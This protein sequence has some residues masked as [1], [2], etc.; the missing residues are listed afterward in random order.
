M[1]D[2]D[3]VLAGIVTQLGSITSLANRASAYGK[4]FTDPP[5]AIV[6]P[7]PGQFIS[8]DSTMGRGSDDLFIVIKLIVGAADDRASQKALNAYL[9]TSGSGS[10]KAAVDG[11]LGG[12][13]SFATVRSARNYG[14]VE[15]AGMMFNGCEFAVEVT[16]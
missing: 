14:D 6:V 2:I 12:A 16:T 3:T 13:V 1:T 9:A 10:V 11:N 8:F 5:W 4:D 7:E 15:W